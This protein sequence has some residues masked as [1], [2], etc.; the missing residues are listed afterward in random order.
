[1][2]KQ[3]RVI[4]ESPL[5]SRPDG[6]RCTPEEF[7]A[8]VSYA[9]AC[10]LDSIKRGEAPFASHVLYPL[11]LNDATPEERRMGMQAGFEWGAVASEVV[12]YVDRGI[13]P[14][15]LEGRQRA[16]DARQFITYRRLGAKPGKS[17][18]IL[19][20]RPVRDYIQFG[21]VGLLLDDPEYQHADPGDFANSLETHDLGD[22]VG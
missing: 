1:M 8:N 9:R 19:F 2:E 5:G 21:E 17:L 4:V 13:T 11:V 6:S 16:R 15:M 3:K 7:E 20:E 10:V 12:V 14:G 18:D 22:A